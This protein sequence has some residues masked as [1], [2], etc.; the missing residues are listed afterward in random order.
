MAEQDEGFLTRW[1]RR[2]AEP[3]APAAPE[4]PAPPEAPESRG[5]L[6][7]AERQALIESLPDVE[8]LDEGSDFSAFMQEGVPEALK[9]RALR[10]LWRLNPIFAQ[11]DGLNDY[12]D[13]FTDAA[14]VVEGMQTLFQVGKGMV[15]P[16]TS[17]EP[18]EA[19]VADSAESAEPT[20]EAAGEA[21]EEPPREGEAIEVV[22]AVEADSA[23]PLPVALAAAQ[24]ENAPAE[25]APRGS[26]RPASARR[27]GLPDA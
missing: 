1:A 25:E 21:A 4:E 19:P 12:D 23:T 20:P 11:L 13:D 7:E 3:E 16:E 17:E 26:G 5:A 27:W 8:S 10:R 24:P 9:R 14:L 18:D 15:T 22:E 2:K 6:T